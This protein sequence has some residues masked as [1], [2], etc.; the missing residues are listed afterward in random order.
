[1]KQ[2]SVLRR[3]LS[4]A[5]LCLLLVGILA[6]SLI[7]A[8]ASPALPAV[9]AGADRRRRPGRARRAAGAE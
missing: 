4:A 9:C 3:S 2:Y 5:G 8:N 7:W 1:M 6:V